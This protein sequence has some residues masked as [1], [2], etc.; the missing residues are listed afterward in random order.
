M[1]DDCAPGHTRTPTNHNMRI[2]YNGKTHYRFP[3]GSHG[4][5]RG[6]KKYQVEFGHVK[7]LIRMLEIMECA[8]G[9]FPQL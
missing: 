5:T 2:A 9:H 7:N 8:K 6:G 1:L 3:L 4:K